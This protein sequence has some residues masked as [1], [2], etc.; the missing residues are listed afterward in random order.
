[1]RDELG[2]FVKGHKG[3][4]FWKGK[5][6]SVDTKRKISEKLKGIKLSEE[7]KKKMSI[8]RKGKPQ[9]WNKGRVQSLEERK[10]RGKK[11]ELHWN[12]KGGVTAEH[13][14]IRKSAEYKF[15]RG[16]VFQR[17]KHTCQ[18]CGKKQ[19]Y[20]RDPNKRI[21]IQADHIKPFST[22][23]D[24]RFEISN[25]RTLCYKC[26]KNTPTYGKKAQNFIFI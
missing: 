11:N 8:A 13:E 7:T 10:K 3:F 6:L 21:I 20:D 17:D 5:N 1:M 4:T 15:W 22:Y 14:K 23:P 16:L 26:H 12:W 19:K 24:L 25:G 9:Y 2:H 18:I